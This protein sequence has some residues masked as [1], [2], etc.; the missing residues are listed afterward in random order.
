MSR[1]TLYVDVARRR[2]DVD[3]H[4]ALG[5]VLQEHIHAIYRS[6]RQ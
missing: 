4:S 3:I 2:A 6:R 5:A 1:E